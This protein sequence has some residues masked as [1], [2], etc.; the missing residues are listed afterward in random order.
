[1]SEDNPSIG[2]VVS[3]SGAQIIF[4]LNR[5]EENALLLGISRLPVEVGSIVKVQASKCVLVGMIRAVSI[6]IPSNEVGVD[7]LKIGEIELLGEIVTHA[8]SSQADFQRGVSVYPALGDEVYLTTQDD[9]R[10]VYAAPRSRTACIGTVHQQASLPA[11]VKIN[12]LLGKHFAVLGTTGS[13]KSC[14]V[15]VILKALLRENPCARILLLDPH[16]EYSQAF[17]A[18][19]QR[20]DPADTLELPYWLF[21][22]DEFCEVVI[23]DDELRCGQTS[24]LAEAI[25]EARRK[26]VN[27]RLNYPVTVD[28]PTPYWMSDV[29]TFLHQAQGKLTRSEP[30]AVYSRLTNRLKKLSD[31]SRFAFMFGRAAAGDNMNALLSKLFRIP[32]NGVPI[33]ITDL[34]GIP[35]E[36]LDVVVSVLCRLTLEF[37]LWSDRTFPILIVC[38]EAHR[39]V[40]RSTSLGFEP[41]KRTLARIAKEGRK[42]GVSL[43]LVSQRPSDLAEDILS[44]CNTIFALR[45]SNQEDHEF[46]RATMSDSGMGLLEFLPSLRAGEAITIGEGVSVPQRLTF[47]ELPANEMPRGRSSSFS[48]AWQSENPASD[49]VKTTIDRWRRLQKTAATG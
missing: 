7:E 29:L 38:E 33:T 43:C 5:A 49:A 24:I 23:D 46:I 41:T 35:S 6:P 28:T 8:Q 17:G 14:A 21:N 12:D 40:P 34:S 11:Y 37:A 22:F 25:T 15:T 4:L 42:Y 18:V 39:Y 48:T 3:V 44:E 1:M 31:D 10:G 26:F 36:I 16:N 27:Y 13:G 20:L 45:M 9:V 2:R 30:L 32:V 47:L 19:A